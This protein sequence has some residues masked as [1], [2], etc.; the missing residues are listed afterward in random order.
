M[1]APVKKEIFLHSCRYCPQNTFR[2]KLRIIIIIIIIIKHNGVGNSRGCT[3]LYFN[4]PKFRTPEV[5]VCGMLCY[6]SSA[7]NITFYRPHNTMTRPEI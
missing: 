5:S 1:K 3:S 2:K 6:N 4:R 7:S